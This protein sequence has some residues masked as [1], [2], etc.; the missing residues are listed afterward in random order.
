M[1]YVLW[2]LYKLILL[3]SG[4]KHV[5]KNRVME[6]TIGLAISHERRVQGLPK[7]ILYPWDT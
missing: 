3:Y 4:T 1:E 5:G 7:I 2:V 6:P